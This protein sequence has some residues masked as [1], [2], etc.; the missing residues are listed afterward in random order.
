MY[1][2][3]VLIVCLALALSTAGY[4]FAQE[5]GGGGLMFEPPF[6][7][8]QVADQAVFRL[9]NFEL[10]EGGSVS[11]DLHIGAGAADCD[12]LAYRAAWDRSSIPANAEVIRVSLVSRMTG[13]RSIVPMPDEPVSAPAVWGAAY[14]SPLMISFYGEDGAAKTD[15]TMEGNLAL[16]TNIRTKSSMSFKIAALRTDGFRF[17]R[18]DRAVRGSAA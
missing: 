3:T 16:A 9:E 14:H 5:L 13:F 18:R 17:D 4:V 15:L 6:L 2:R 10:G 11:F 12:E 7:T 1:K 8:A